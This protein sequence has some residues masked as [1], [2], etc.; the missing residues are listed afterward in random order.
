MQEQQQVTT[1]DQKINLIQ[2]IT[3]LPALTIMVFLRRKVGYR[4]LDLMKIQIMV[5]LLWALS[6]FSGATGGPAAGAIVFL[7]AL[8]VL[9]AAYV[10]RGARWREIKRGVAWHS[11][12]RGVSWFSAFLPLRETTVRRFI[13]PLTALI[14]GIVFFMLFRWFG[15]YII[16][17]AVCLFLF[18]T[19][20]YQKQIDRML[21]QLDNLIE[22]EV[23]AENTE[24]FQSG[25]AGAAKERPIAQTAGIP[26]GTDPDLAAAIERRR[27][28]S[29]GSRKAQPAAEPEPPA[30]PEQRVLRP[31]MRDRD[32]ISHQPE[33][34][35][36]YT[37][38]YAYT[39]QEEAPAQLREPSA[40]AEPLQ[41]EAAPDL[42]DAIERRRARSRKRVSAEPLQAAAMQTQSNQEEIPVIQSP[43]D[44]AF[45]ALPSGAEFRT[46]DGKKRIKR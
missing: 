29:R 8:A 31:L 26:T 12:S 4:F 25:G 9:I 34:P 33:P 27:A 46:P 14:I 3:L 5:V 38:P 37:D 19:I 11:Y 16:F 13:D 6:V 42:A 35:I 24:Y 2:N 15:L 43:D 28:R 32:I 20:D 17:C 41:E 10:E 40:Q 44:P 23:V 21:D 36:L 39:A 1:L 7:F 30:A 18:E 22:S 45:M